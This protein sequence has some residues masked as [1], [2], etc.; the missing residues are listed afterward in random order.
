MTLVEYVSDWV[1][2]AGLHVEEV[3]YC[4]TF[5]RGVQPR[6]ALRGLGIEDADIRTGTWNELTDY[7]DSR[8]PR[9]HYNATTAFSVGE[10]AVVVEDRGYRGSLPE[11]QLALSE[12]TELI[13][14]HEV[15]VR[16]CQQLTIVENGAQVACVHGDDLADGP[17]DRPDGLKA[18]QTEDEELAARL[19][20]LI[21]SAL[22]PFEK[23]DEPPEDFEDG[24]VDL[25][26]VA[27]DYLGLRP[28]VRHIEGPLLGA[29][30]SLLPV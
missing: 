5:V 20:L 29:A 8:E 15:P 2:E 1:D 10:F 19:S 6:A 13:N 14:V 4:I 24:W 12:G 16:G 9:G 25:L 26:Q 11:W 28:A 23:G 7:A 22:R 3:G 30:V 18:V 17:E 21:R 27:C